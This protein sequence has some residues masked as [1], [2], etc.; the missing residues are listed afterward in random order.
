MSCPED[1]I[2]AAAADGLV[3]ELSASGGIRYNGVEETVDC[4][5]HRLRQHK[6]EIVALLK[7]LPRWC[8]PDCPNLE[9][10]VLPG[11]GLM[12]GCVNPEDWRHWRRL[13]KV[14]SCPARKKPSANRS[15]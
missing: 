8:R 14:T 12:A 13:G 1:I 6:N 9:T 7:Q 4:W 3:I 2:R 11:E 10:H 5:L 15:Q